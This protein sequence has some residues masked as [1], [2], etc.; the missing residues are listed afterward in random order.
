MAQKRGPNPS[1]Q[2]KI[3]YPERLSFQRKRGEVVPLALFR[4]PSISFSSLRYCNL[5]L[6]ISLEGNKPY[7]TIFTDKENGLPFCP[8]MK[9]SIPCSMHKGSCQKQGKDRE[10][11]C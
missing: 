10:T 9:V 5:F 11:I 1:E 4:S 6:T 3:G 7:T 2:S 8:F